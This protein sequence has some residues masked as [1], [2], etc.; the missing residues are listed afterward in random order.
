MARGVSSNFL[1]IARRE[2]RLGRRAALAALALAPV[3]AFLAE[4]A[5]A[6]AYGPVW[7]LFLLA[8]LAGLGLGYLGTQRRLARYEG[9]LRLRWNHWMLRARDVERLADVERRVHERD[10]LPAMVWSA[11]TVAMVALNI[12]LFALLWVEHPA[13]P[14]M[15]WLLLALDG[16]VLGA[17]VTSSALLVRWARDF[18]RSAEA[19]VRN[20]EVAMWGE[21]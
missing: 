15:A 16:L 9:D 4:L 7:V 2:Q 20:G 14:P 3:A 17:L 18:V 19:L 1:D 8:C 11:A 12:L 5:D 10:P 21:R 13:A 6:P